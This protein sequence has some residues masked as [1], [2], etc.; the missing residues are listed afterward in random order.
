VRFLVEFSN[1]PKINDIP[2]G[3]VNEWP[4][5]HRRPALMTDTV[6]TDI[7]EKNTLLENKF[8]F[9]L[10]RIPHVKYFMTK[11]TLPGLS[12][13]SIDQPTMFRT[14]RQPGTKAEFDQN[15]TLEFDVDVD[16]QNWIEIFRWMRGLS[17]PDE[18]QQY[19]DLK[20]SN[21]AWQDNA[22][23]V[24]DGRLILYTNRFTQNMNIVFTDM[25]PINLSPLQLQSTSS[26]VLTASATFAYS[27]FDIE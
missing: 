13:A 19:K 22:R 17:F 6:L 15:F 21:N 20:T 25:F 5:Y 1:D 24:S 3:F 27:K 18:F 10:S 11:T 14:L 8:A 12:I 9:E 16:L 23:V 4:K 7:V 2:Y 26:E